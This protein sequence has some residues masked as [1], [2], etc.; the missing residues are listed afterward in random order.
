MIKMYSEGA[1]DIIMQSRSLTPLCFSL[2]LPWCETPQSI[3][4]K[5]IPLKWTWPKVSSNRS[6]SYHKMKFGFSISV[7]YYGAPLP[8]L[9]SKWDTKSWGDGCGGDPSTP[10]KIRENMER[11]PTSN[12][13][14]NV[15]I[16]NSSSN[17]PATTIVSIQK[18][19]FK[20]HRCSDRSF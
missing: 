4:N 20:W 13:Y 15:V 3:Q 10:I 7:T 6:W 8:S 2:T 12:A 1:N 19:S 16:K 14:L 11:L 17:L 5:Y 9:K 18:Y